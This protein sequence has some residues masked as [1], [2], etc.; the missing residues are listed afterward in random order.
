MPKPC[1]S[2][3]VR[4]CPKKRLPAEQVDVDLMR[5]MRKLNDCTA[6]LEVPET[7]STGS[8]QQ[9]GTTPAA[10]RRRCSDGQKPFYW[11]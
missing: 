1:K 3:K 5:E 10:P 2:G 4:K 6:T 11:F 8:V 7:E 9:T